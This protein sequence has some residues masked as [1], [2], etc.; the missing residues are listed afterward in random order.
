MR[1]PNAISIVLFIVPSASSFSEVS[2]KKQTPP[3]CIR[4]A[5]KLS[6]HAQLLFLSLYFRTLYY[7]GNRKFEVGERFN[8]QARI[9]QGWRKAHS[10]YKQ[11]YNWSTIGQVW[12]H[13]RWRFNPRNYDSWTQL[14]IRHKFLM[15]IQIEHTNWWL[16]KEDQPLCRRWRFWMQGGQD[17]QSS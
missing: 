11:W 7:M 14:Q 2:P 6:C 9:C 3:K 12:N 13:L 15:A 16:E 17:Q 4:Y 8:L 5:M 10:D 1:S